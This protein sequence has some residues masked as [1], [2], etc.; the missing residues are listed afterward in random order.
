MRHQGRLTEWNDD[1]GFGFITPLDGQPRVFVHVS[2][3]PQE[4]RRPL[5]M[6]LVTYEL[7]NDE[8]G[9]PRADDVQFMAP[10]RTAG[11]QDL[12][13]HRSRGSKPSAFVLAALAVLV[14]AI[15]AGAYVASAAVRSAKSPVAPPTAP[16]S[17]PAPAST[18][19][20]TP[21]GTTDANP[22][23]SIELAPN[24]PPKEPKTSGG[25]AARGTGSAATAAEPPAPG[26]SV[27]GQAFRT[28]ASGIE[29]VGGGTVTKLL[30][31]DTDGGRH[32]RFI[33]RLSSGQ[34]LLLAHNIDI[35]PRIAGLG[36]G[37]TVEFKGQYEWNA[38]GGVVHWTHHDPS[39]THVEGWLKHGSQ[40][41]R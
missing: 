26:D 21:T 12:A 20:A 38:Q 19:G 37:D 2:A 1:R 8:R 40:T 22:A 10:T 39:G 30:A 16:L 14:V 7:A 17:T 33:V 15:A 6:D 24:R 32:Q 31:D 34:T 28:H 25:P 27:I 3:F 4:L 29:V 23:S 11:G 35:A 41:S 13:S 18:T 9:R 5:V 36:I